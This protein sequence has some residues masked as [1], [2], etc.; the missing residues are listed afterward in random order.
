VRGSGI[1]EGTDRFGQHLRRERGQVR[2][3][4]KRLRIGPFLPFRRLGFW[5][6]GPQSV[7]AEFFECFGEVFHAFGRAQPE[8]LR[9]GIAQGGGPFNGGFLACIVGIKG[10]QRAAALQGVG[11]PRAQSCSAKGNSRR[12]GR[13]MEGEGVQRGFRDSER[14][15]VAASFEGR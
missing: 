3:R 7:S 12:C 9:P 10:E 15:S 11:E 8:R 1:H 14:I 6:G 13:E 4:V 2:E 5:H